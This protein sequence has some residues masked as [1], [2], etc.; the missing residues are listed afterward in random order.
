MYDKTKLKKLFDGYYDVNDLLEK[1][2]TSTDMNS[3]PAD[4]EIFGNLLE[5]YF[6]NDYEFVQ[7]FPI[8]HVGHHIPPSKETLVN[9]IEKNKSE[10]KFSSCS[11]HTYL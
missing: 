5:K 10:G 2:Y 4:Q 9:F 7:D 6:P 3:Y 11:Y 1:C 8:L